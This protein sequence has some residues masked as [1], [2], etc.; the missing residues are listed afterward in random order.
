MH[1]LHVKFLN[2]YLLFTVLLLLLL[3]AYALRRTSSLWEI[4]SVPHANTIENVC[5]TN[6]YGP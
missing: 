6:S 1:I 4:E 5:K 2:Y 3:L